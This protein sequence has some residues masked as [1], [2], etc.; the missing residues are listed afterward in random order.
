MYKC[1]R[2]KEITDILGQTGYAT[3]EYLSQKLHIS[4]SS[5]RRDLSV[6]ESRGILRRSYGGAEL[7]DAAKKSIPF[8]MRSHEN[9]AE[10][11]RIAAI[12]A[13]LVREGDVVFLDGSS[14]CFFL[15]RE[16]VG[17][18]GITIVTNGV[19]ALSFLSSYRIRT[20]S[21][22]GRISEDNRAALVGEAAVKC[23]EDMRADIAFFSTQALDG[24]G[25]IF[26]CYAEEIPARRAMVKNA[27]KCVYLCDGS[28]R[29]TVSTYRVLSLSSVDVAVGDTPFPLEY[30]KKFLGV[31]FLP[32]P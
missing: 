22:G 9:S 29:G 6:L 15:L 16:L 1:E 19:D 13:G 24:E 27:E 4:P 14:T 7:S 20:V 23:F 2:E 5:V 28:K 12:A 18:R 10:K 3:V 8:S 32:E 26:D 30:R 25:N 17:I 11:R 21:T 31:T